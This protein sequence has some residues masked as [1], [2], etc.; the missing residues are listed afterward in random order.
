MKRQKRAR[1]LGVNVQNWEERDTRRVQGIGDAGWLDGRI[2]GAKGWEKQ[3]VPDREA[4]QGDLDFILGEVRASCQCF[5]NW[6]ASRLVFCSE[7]CDSTLNADW[8][9]TKPPVGPVVIT[10]TLKWL[11]ESSGCGSRGGGVRRNTWHSGA[12]SQRQPV[13]ARS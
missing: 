8:V 1:K 9:V 13:A 2:D 6:K 12:T 4:L 11:P 3:M 10:S 7:R 5:Y